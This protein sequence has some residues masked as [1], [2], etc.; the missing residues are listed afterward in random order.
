MKAHNI[1]S[2]TLSNRLILCMSF[3]TP[4]IAQA[5]VNAQIVPVKSDTGTTIQ[6]NQNLINISGG[7]ASA[8][9]GNL[10]HSFS[11][12]NVNTGQ[13][14]NFLSTPN[15]QNILTPSIFYPSTNQL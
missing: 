3:L 4:L 12:F 10:F 11:Q 1:Q 9:G 6:Q 2:S 13:V 7:A 5:N 15:V 14:A 8:K